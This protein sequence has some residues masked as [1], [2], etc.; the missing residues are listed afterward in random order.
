MGIAAYNRGTKA[1]RDDISKELN[2]APKILAETLILAE[3]RRKARD[4]WRQDAMSFMV[5]SYMFKKCQEHMSARRGYQTRRNTM[6]TAHTAWIDA[7]GELELNQASKNYAQSV[8]SYISWVVGSW[9]V[10]DKILS[11]YK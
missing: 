5:D 7:S 9:N 10:A 11:E 6:L 2:L 1:Q 8:Y 4:K 3:I